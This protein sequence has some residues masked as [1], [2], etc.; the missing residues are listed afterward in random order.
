[1]IDAVVAWVD[2]SDPAHAAKRARYMGGEAGTERGGLLPT[3]FASS[4]ELRYCIHLIRKN[5]R[6]IRRIFL[7][8]DNQVPDWLDD[9]VRRDLAVTIVDHRQIFRGYEDVLP[10][11][12]S[13]SIE[14]VI[15]RIE[16]LSERFVY[17]NDDMFIV[18]PVDEA[19]YFDGDVP[20]IRGVTVHKSILPKPIKNWV[21]GGRY[22]PGLVKPR[23][24]G[25]R[26][27]RRRVAIAHT[28]HPVNRE[29]FAATIGADRIARNVQFRFRNRRQFSALCLYA[30]LGVVSGQVRLVE[31]DLAYVIP[32]AF[33]SI[34]IDLLRRLTGDGTVR[35]LCIQSL[36][37]YDEDS[38]RAAWAFLD[39]LI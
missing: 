19:D 21:Y 15:H 17:F 27:G 34:D 32:H 22:V 8:T 10:T 1:V 6:W 5:A 24:G 33:P 26:I 39:S 11:F 18:A 36:D 35:H 9:Q 13:R 31:P 37:A 16:G 7:V 28:P 12:S 14:T 23:L 3:R 25:E 4:G 2:G 29:T 30:T 20:L 38:R